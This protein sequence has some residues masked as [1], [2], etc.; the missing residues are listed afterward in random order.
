[1]IE[2]QRVPVEWAPRT[3][4]LVCEW[5]DAA[6]PVA[7]D[8]TIDDLRVAV[9][10]GRSV[11]FVAV[12]EGKIRGAAVVELF[13]RGLQRVAFVSA[14][15]GRLITGPETF[16]QFKAHLVSLGATQLEGAARESAARLWGRFGLTE[17]YR[18][19]G[20][21]LWAEAAANKPQ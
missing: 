6:L 14:M 20:A 11:L 5:L 2:I 17:K 18:I 8:V 19:V 21:S 4:P 16:A 9:F 12:K 7:N 15:G 3:W 1:V 13:N 10:A